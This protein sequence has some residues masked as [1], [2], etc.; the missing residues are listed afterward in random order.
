MHIS[1]NTFLPLQYQQGS[2]LGHILKSDLAFH[3]LK[4]SWWANALSHASL[5]FTLVDTPCWV[6]HGWMAGPKELWSMELN[7]VG[8]QSQ[9]ASPRAQCWGRFCLISSLMILMRGLSAPSVSLQT[10]PSWDG[11]L[12]CQRGRRALQR[13]LDRL[14]RWAK[15][16]SMSFNRAKCQGLHFGHNN[17]KQPY[18]LGEEW[19]ESCL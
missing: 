6:K 17:P 2:L 16:N 15:V 1:S 11:A 12:I 7:P 5:Y 18:R 9:A 10:T 4:S 14:D 19:L 13:D 8:G 3:C